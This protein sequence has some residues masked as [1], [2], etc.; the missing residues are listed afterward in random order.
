MIR[1]RNGVPEAMHLSAHSDGNSW[2]WDAFEKKGDRPVIY[3]AIGSHANYPNAG[4]HAYSGVFLVGPTDSTNTGHLWD[5]A[6]NFV[7]AKSVVPSSEDPHP[8]SKYAYLSSSAPGFNKS[9]SAEDVET[10][11]TFEGRWGNSF[12]DLRA[13]AK[14]KSAR[15]SAGHSAEGSTS[16]SSSDGV[17]AD[18]T[19]AGSRSIKSPLAPLSN[20]YKKLRGKG[21][22]S[23]GQALR[24]AEAEAVKGQGPK[25]LGQVSEGQTEK[26]PMVDLSMLDI[27]TKLL[28]LIWAEGPTGPRDKS[29]ERQGMNRWKEG[30][31]DAIG[32]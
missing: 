16:S 1:F 23:S 15:G 11:L 9:Y 26:K 13:R 30:M 4:T 31:L 32:K 2:K 18:K 27:K 17:G 5:P 8:C 22:L 28:I 21:D 14:G 25:V 6:L 3:A 12:S 19:S 7:C 10:V 20:L 29:L 24:A